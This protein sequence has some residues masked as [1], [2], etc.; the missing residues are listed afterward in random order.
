MATLNLTKDQFAD[1]AMIWFL[2]QIVNDE[3]ITNERFAEFVDQHKNKLKAPLLNYY[4]NT[5]SQRRLEYRR[6][7][8]IFS[9]KENQIQQIRISPDE[10]EKEKSKKKESRLKKVAKKVINKVLAK[11]ELNLEDVNILKEVRNAYD[12]VPEKDDIQQGEG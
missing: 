9:G 12:E 3:R 8:G 1:V 7:S 4:L 2:D 6:I 5:P 10:K 11:E